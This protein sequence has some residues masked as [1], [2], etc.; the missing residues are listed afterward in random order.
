MNT[1]KPKL[2]PKLKQVIKIKKGDKRKG[3]GDKRK[4]E[5]D[6]DDDGDE[7]EDEGDEPEGEGDEPEEKDEEEYRVFAY[8]IHGTIDKDTS[9]IDDT[10]N[11]DSRKK[12]IYDLRYWA[13]KRL[14]AELKKT[15][16]PVEWEN[17]NAYY[18]RHNEN[19]I[20]QKM[21]TPPVYWSPI[22]T[23]GKLTEKIS[24]A[25]FFKKYEFGNAE[26]EE[27]NIQ[28]LRTIAKQL[29]DNNTVL[30]Y[31]FSIGGL[32]VQRICEVLNI[33][34]KNGKLSELILGVELE[35]EYIER[36]KV[37]TFGSL[38]ISPFERVQNIHIQ[39]Y[40][41]RDD[42][43]T[44][45]N[46]FEF[47]LG[48]L[49]PKFDDENAQ[50]GFVY[51]RRREKLYHYLNLYDNNI[52]YLQKWNTSWLFWNDEEEIKHKNFLEYSVP[53]LKALHNEH[54]QKYDLL[55]NKLLKAHTHSLFELENIDRVEEEKEEIILETSPIDIE[56]VEPLDTVE[57]LVQ[58]M[59][60]LTPIFY[61]NE[62]D[63]IME[64][65]RKNRINKK[66]KAVKEARQEYDEAN[67]ILSDQNTQRTTR[68]LRR[69][70]LKEIRQEIN[71]ISHH[72]AV[73]ILD[74]YKEQNKP[75]SNA[76]NPEENMLDFSLIMGQLE[77]NAM[78]LKGDGL[79][80][81]R[82]LT[83]DAINRG[84][85]NRVRLPISAAAAGGGS[86]GG[87]KSK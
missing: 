54:N 16:E 81:L 7:D 82:T 73:D 72:A 12:Y 66:L 37:A 10:D 78:F 14:N 41:M 29:Y 15:Q 27:A 58:G 2:K 51:N 69:N 28:L 18:Y 48:F 64:T 32:V 19:S 23:L 71:D 20:W 38:Y 3:E 11:L 84:K 24:E 44:R 86:G 76:E 43:A 13:W 1:P 36:L 33:C 52:V 70:A 5:G 77:A 68:L 80:N 87:G 46:F 63:Y 62:R 47:G 85:S 60:T 75:L 39:N 61:V 59:V 57:E 8:I 4:G 45:T 55:F 74:L 31:G 50:V 30:L 42:V 79:L 34:L 83:T 17:V 22:E 26:L 65:T 49:V 6:E 21:F 40:M 53:Q 9:K 56:I 25:G 35:Q 67:S